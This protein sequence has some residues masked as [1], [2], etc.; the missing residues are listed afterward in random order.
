MLCV[1]RDSEA[2]LVAR[3][4]DTREIRFAI[5]LYGLPAVICWGI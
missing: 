1:G 5:P 2:Y 4:V 3:P